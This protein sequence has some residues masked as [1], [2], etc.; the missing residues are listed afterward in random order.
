MTL[1]RLDR[2]IAKLAESIAPETVWGDY[3]QTCS[4]D[5][6][7]EASKKALVREFLQQARPASVLDIGCNTGDYSR[8]AAECGA[9]VLATDFDIGAVEQ[10]YRRLKKSPPPSPRWSWTLPIRARASAT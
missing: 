1:R 3:T 7:A 6:A 5:D 4:Y 10:M 8:I 9:H 2:K